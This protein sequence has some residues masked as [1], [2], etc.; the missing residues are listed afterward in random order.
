MTANGEELDFVIMGLFMLILLFLLF[1]SQSWLFGC[2]E[3]GSETYYLHVFF[4]AS[5]LNSIHMDEM[6]NSF[7]N[8]ISPYS[9]GDK[10]AAQS[11]NEC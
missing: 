1:F 5:T 7:K 4:L 10:D 2:C 3:E 9:H 6:E 8:S 11:T